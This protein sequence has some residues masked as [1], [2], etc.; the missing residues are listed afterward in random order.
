MLCSG[1]LAGTSN[2]STSDS[3]VHRARAI[4]RLTTYHYG[5]N[6]HAI[7]IPPEHIQRMI[8]K[9]QVSALRMPARYHKPL[10]LNCCLKL[11]E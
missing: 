7:P 10:A 2:G 4:P 3:D 11:L 5:V 1:R 8:L 9:H 6:V